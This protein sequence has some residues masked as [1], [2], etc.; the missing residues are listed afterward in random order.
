MCSHNDLLG[1]KCLGCLSLNQSEIQAQQLA[2]S[3][4]VLQAA[5]IRQRVAQLRA[6]EAAWEQRKGAQLFQTMNSP[7][8][9]LY[10]NNMSAG[11]PSA[12][13]QAQR[14]AAERRRVEEQRRFDEEIKRDMDATFRRQMADQER[15]HNA[16]MAG[17]MR[18]QRNMAGLEAAAAAGRAAAHRSGGGGGGGSNSSIADGFLWEPPVY[19]SGNSMANGFRW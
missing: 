18:H 4:A 9:R 15:H 17:Q 14:D 1:I 2:V 16:L 7:L 5:M 3:G 12:Q 13:S 10:N 19:E 6:A 11:V 8:V